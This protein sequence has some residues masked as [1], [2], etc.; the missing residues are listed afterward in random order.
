M[1]DISMCAWLAGEK[2]QTRRQNFATQPKVGWYLLGDISAD[3]HIE[4]P[5]VPGDIVYLKEALLPGSKS[6]ICIS[7]VW[8]EIVTTM[9]K[10]DLTPVKWQPGMVHNGKP[11]EEYQGNVIWPWEAQYTPSALMP[12]WAAREWAIVKDV[13]AER[14]RDISAQDVLAEGVI[15]RWWPPKRP[16]WSYGGRKVGRFYKGKNAYFAVWDIINGHG[17]SAENPYVWRIVLERCA[18]PEENDM[19]DDDK[20]ITMK[21]AKRPGLVNTVPIDV[22]VISSSKRRSAPWSDCCPVGTHDHAIPVPIAGRVQGIDFCIAHIVAAL[23][24]GGIETVAS[25]CGHGKQ[26]GHI[27]LADGRELIIKQKSEKKC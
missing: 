25:C 26:N 23:N 14:L 10:A 5:L 18:K 15:R 9:Y 2:T 19:E 22:N 24:A 8:Q 20:D 16:M 1:C 21:I 11:L 7:G 3:P 17:A 6:I 13:R 27:T 4:P 12:K